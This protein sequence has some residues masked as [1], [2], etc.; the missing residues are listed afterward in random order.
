M[1]PYSV[2]LGLA[3]GYSFHYVTNLL[4]EELHYRPC[5]TYNTEHLIIRFWQNI[6]FD[7]ST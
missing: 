6:Y 5:L 1:Q 2:H 7:V 4:A 3:R